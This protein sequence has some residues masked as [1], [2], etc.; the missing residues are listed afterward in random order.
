MGRGLRKKTKTANKQK[1]KKC[2]RNYE[3]KNEDRLSSALWTMKS[4]ETWNTEDGYE[5]NPKF[6]FETREWC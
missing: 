6:Y 5:L 2:V 3:I 4:K 1:N